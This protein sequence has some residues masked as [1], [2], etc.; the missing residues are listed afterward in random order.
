MKQGQVECQQAHTI[1]KAKLPGAQVIGRQVHT[2]MLK[3]H[4]KNRC[5]QSSLALKG[6]SINDHHQTHANAYVLAY[7]WCKF[8]H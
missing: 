3:L 6:R 4:W 5:C 7:P 8:Y 1:E 2:I